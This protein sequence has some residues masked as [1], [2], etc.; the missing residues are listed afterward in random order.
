MPQIPPLVARLAYTMHA[1]NVFC[2][3]RVS[4]TYQYH[5]SLLLEKLAV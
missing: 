5:K 4:L 3:G 2:S 1:S